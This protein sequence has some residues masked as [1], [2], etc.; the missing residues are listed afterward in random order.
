MYEIDI[1]STGS[2]QHCK[3]PQGPCEPPEEA[4]DEAV[5]DA[6]DGATKRSPKWSLKRSSNNVIIGR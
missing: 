2:P 6:P 4:S 3:L 5:D 1:A